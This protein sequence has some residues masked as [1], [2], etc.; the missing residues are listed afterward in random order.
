MRLLEYLIFSV[1]INDLLQQFE[2]QFLEPILEALNMGNAR[3]TPLNYPYMFATE[4]YEILVVA[5]YF[6]S[7]GISPLL[8]Y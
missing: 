1:S 8:N 2:Q 3:G 5:S 4:L 7:T 6:D